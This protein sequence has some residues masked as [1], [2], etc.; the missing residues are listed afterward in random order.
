MSQ[1][2]TF[3]FRKYDKVLSPELLSKRETY[4]PV[5]SCLVAA[6]ADVQPQKFSIF[7]NMHT[8]IY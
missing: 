4:F 8:A 5:F 7:A 3:F 1:I 2:S 6:L